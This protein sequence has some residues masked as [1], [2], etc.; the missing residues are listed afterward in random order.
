MSEVKGENAWLHINSIEGGRAAVLL[1]MMED[2]LQNGA[3]QSLETI[4]DKYDMKFISAAHN[5]DFLKQPIKDEKTDSI[6][7]KKAERAA[8]LVEFYN[9]ATTHLPHQSWSQWKAQK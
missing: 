1:V 8:F 5:T 9:F 2:I 3:E 4:A 7:E 6:T